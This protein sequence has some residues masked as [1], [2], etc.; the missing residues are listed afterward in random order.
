MA[1]DKIYELLGDQAKYLLEHKS[2]AIS[3]DQIHL[4]IQFRP[5]PHTHPH[6]YNRPPPTA[7]PRP[8]SAVRRAAVSCRRAGAVGPC[9]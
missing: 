6:E 8:D 9:S 3:K 1:T 4:P 5:R 2:K 7:V